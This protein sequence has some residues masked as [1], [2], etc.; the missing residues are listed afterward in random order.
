MKKNIF[1]H[2]LYQISLFIQFSILFAQEIKC[3]VNFGYVFTEPLHNGVECDIRTI[4]SG[5]KLVLNS[6]F[7]FYF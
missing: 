2:I 6:D 1:I 7:S 3:V 4:L 5:I